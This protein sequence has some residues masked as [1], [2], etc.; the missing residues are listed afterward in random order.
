MI[1]KWKGGRKLARY[2]DQSTR[3]SRVAP[4]LIQIGFRDKRIA[5][6]AGM[7]EFGNPSTNLPEWPAFRLGI[8]EA[9]RAIRDYLAK[10][11][12]ANRR[13]AIGLTPE[14]WRELA[15][16]ARDATRQ[17]YMEFHEGPGLSER[18]RERKAG[19]SFADDELIGA[20][21]PKLI[22]HIH[23]YVGGIQV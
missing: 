3:A 18:Q 10:A 4:P 9:E 17:S 7:L 12:L 22:G 19:T 6:L 1:A 5:P 13:K 21:G 14:Q 15:I 8:P 16:I 23:A 2:I 20:E 11:L